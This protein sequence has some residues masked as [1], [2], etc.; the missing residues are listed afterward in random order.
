MTSVL[1]LINRPLIV[2]VGIPVVLGMSSGLITQ[3]SVRDWYPTIKKPS[4]T[5][6]NWVFGPVWTTLYAS[7]GYASYLIYKAGVERPFLDTTGPLQLYATQ[8]A[9]NVLWTP[10][11][12]G[13]HQLGAASL[14]IVA[15]FGTIVATTREFGKIDRLAGWLMVPYAAWVAYA[16]SIT[17]YVWWNNKDTKG[18]KN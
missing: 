18:K 12:F 13:V 4:W 6:P 7:M 2:S 16:G 8:L 15:L 1:S 11:F 5:P 14:D 3:K 10:L 9:L 17:L